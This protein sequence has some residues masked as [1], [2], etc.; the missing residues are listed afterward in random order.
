MHD[1][2][3]VSLLEQDTMRKGRVDKALP[4]P[5]KDVEFETG[6]NKKYVVKVIINNAVYD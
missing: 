1:I 6:G 5:D 3:H 4:E 2:F